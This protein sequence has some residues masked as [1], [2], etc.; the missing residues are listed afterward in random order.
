MRCAL[1]VNWTLGAFGEHHEILNAPVVVYVGVIL[2]KPS[3]GF[4]GL[5]SF[6]TENALQNWP[7]ASE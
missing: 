2:A 3:Y 6:A 4:W 7:G 1:G 5:H